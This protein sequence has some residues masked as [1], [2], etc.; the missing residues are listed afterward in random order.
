MNVTPPSKLSALDPYTEALLLACQGEDPHQVK[1]ALDTLNEDWPG[2]AA[3]PFLRPLLS[4]WWDEPQILEVLL[5]VYSVVASFAAAPEI[6]ALLGHPH[7][8]VVSAAAIVLDDIGDARLGER[9]LEALLPLTRHGD[10]EVQET[11]AHV[12]TQLDG[13]DGPQPLSPGRLTDVVLGLLEHD[14]RQVRACVARE[15]VGWD[16]ERERVDGVMARYV[17]S[18][19]PSLCAPALTRLGTSGDQAALERLM[20]VLREPD[21]H[22]EF[23]TA[24]ARVGCDHGSRKVKRALRRELKRLRSEGWPGRDPESR[25]NRM[26]NALSLLSSNPLSGWL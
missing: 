18:S 15:L 7:P 25:V 6:F 4:R 10:A 14:T 16:Y 17:H 22:P 12:I 2:D 23:I 24:A 19:D 26:K 21:P 13:W 5:E 11:A 9:A 1:A 20:A 3:E 8:A